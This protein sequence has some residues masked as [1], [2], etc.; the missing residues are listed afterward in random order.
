MMEKVKI[1][2]I[3]LNKNYVQATHAYS[4]RQN[5]SCVPLYQALASD[6]INL[7]SMTLSTFGNQSFVSGT[8]ASKHFGQVSC[9]NGYWNCHKNVCTI[10]IYPHHYR[11]QPLGFLLYLLGIQKVPFHCL[12][13]SNAMLTF[14]VAQTDCDTVIDILSKN[15][16]LPES[17]VPFEQKE[18]E[19]LTQFLKKKYPETRATYVEEKIKTYG[20]TLVSDLHLSSYLFSFDQL[21][22]YGQMIQ[23][24]DDKKDK[25]L[26]VSAIMATSTQ[27]HLFLVTKKSL[28][29]PAPQTCAAELIS[30]HGPHFGDRHSIISRALHC[31]SEKSIRVLQTGC[32][33]ASIGIVLPEGRGKEAKRAL[34]DVFEIP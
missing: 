2:G 32:T 20:I 34:K 15:F 6:R 25:F 21:A 9:Q 26:F 17:H 12:I 19:M 18:N 30:F 29:I 13:S 1:N 8:I 4:D 14:V 22:E 23:S 24:R 10:S 27:I 31:L 11:L 28:D 33:G 7:V 3:R 5:Q 16:D